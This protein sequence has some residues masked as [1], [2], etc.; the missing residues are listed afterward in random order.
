MTKS[1]R[2]TVENSNNFSQQ[3][4]LWKA[5]ELSIHW[6]TPLVS[7]PP[8]SPP[9]IHHPLIHPHPT[10]SFVICFFL[11]GTFVQNG[12]KKDQTLAGTYEKIVQKLV[13]NG[14][15]LTQQWLVLLKFLPDSSPAL[16]V[17]NCLK[18]GRFWGLLLIVL[19]TKW[20]GCMFGG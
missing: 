3:C 16:L 2:K 4:H 19:L 11:R 1:S 12:S 10:N 8:D 6:F 5:E 9:L 7:P 17:L 15:K 20:T 18:M 14:K 13:K